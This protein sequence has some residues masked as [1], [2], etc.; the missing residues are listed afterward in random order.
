MVDGQ[1][2]ARYRQMFRHVRERYWRDNWYD[3]RMQHLL[4]KI[5]CGNDKSL[6]ECS[7]DSEGGPVD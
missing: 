2:K 7:L 1:R 5:R 3:H 4:K 6:A